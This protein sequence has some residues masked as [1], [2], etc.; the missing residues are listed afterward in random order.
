M[1]Y[2]L[3]YIAKKEKYIIYFHQ[4]KQSFVWAIVKEI[5][6][7]CKKNQRKLTPKDDVPEVEPIIDSV[8]TINYEKYIKIRRVYKCKARMNVHGRHKEYDK[9]YT[10]SHSP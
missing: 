2:H 6:G 7:H 10:E 4:T 9:K 3:S 8:C 5:N 1:A